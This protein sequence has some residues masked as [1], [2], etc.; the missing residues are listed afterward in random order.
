[1]I[2]RHFKINTLITYASN[3]IVMGSGFILMFMIN[4]FA[5]V[6]AYGELAII[7]STAGI[8]VSLVTARSGEAVTRFFVREKALGNM[9]NAKLVV[10]IGLCIDFILGIFLFF[11]FYLLSDFIANKFLDNPASSYSVWIYGF[12]TLLTFV[13]GSMKGYFQSHEYFKVL[14]SIQV[15]E[16][17][18]KVIFLLFSFFVLK[19]VD[20]NFIIYSYILASFLVTLYIMIIFSIRFF[21]EFKEVKLKID[22]DLVKEYFSFN[23]KTFFSTTLSS[24]N[25]G[26]DNILLGYFT[27]TK[28]VGIYQTLKNILSPTSFISAPFEMMT[29]SKLTK[30]YD[31]KQ[32]K[33]FINIIQKITILIFFINI[34]ILSIIFYF[35]T[36]ILSYFSIYEV[37]YI[38]FILY[39]IAVMIKR[40][41]WWN[42]IVMNLY[43]PLI[44]GYQSLIFFISFLS[45]IFIMSV[46]MQITFIHIIFSSLISSLMMVMI[47]YIVLKKITRW[48]Y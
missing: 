32:F 48:K 23:M 10:L 13:R 9:Q 25:N 46:F 22:I 41:I 11:F 4:R 35:L 27:D 31:K 20:I 12:I 30:F 39:A 6:N 28:T 37:L 45:I 17:I 38:E 19:N 7:I 1:M 33:D 36:D 15:L 26:I 40:S 34:I 3:A 18:L 29:V 5:G 14:N 44:I 24:L 8:L 16:S 42:N 47:S 43:N 2:N 21:R